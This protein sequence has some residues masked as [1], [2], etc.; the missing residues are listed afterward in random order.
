MI[1]EVGI[2]KNFK[3]CLLLAIVFLFSSISCFG[4]QNVV[5]TKQEIL[6]NEIGLNAAKK[7]VGKEL[8][9]DYH[10]GIIEDDGRR[11]N[12]SRKDLSIKLKE[13]IVN[14]EI[15]SFIEIR[16]NKIVKT[17]KPK[18]LVSNVYWRPG[19][20][21]FI[22]LEEL[23]T[24]EGADLRNC[25]VNNVFVEMDNGNL[26]TK[27]ISDPSQPSTDMAWSSNGRYLVFSKSSQIMIKEYNS[28]KIW[29]AKSINIKNRK[30]RIVSGSPAWIGQFFW[31][32]NNKK[33]IFKWKEHYYYDEPSGYAIIDVSQFG[34]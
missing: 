33:I 6:A 18:G 11:F 20:T 2:L 9:E 30:K 34:I 15:I 4:N 17:L 14:E 7:M 28:R 3:M 23:P 8:F 10:F 29:T 27:I 25:I 21:S 31:V 24:E 32:D 26:K 1:L 5:K 13:S 16:W 12:S 22:Y 19:T